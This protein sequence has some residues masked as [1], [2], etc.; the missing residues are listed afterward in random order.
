MPCEKKWNSLLIKVKLELE[1][2]AAAE[3]IA[4]REMEVLAALAEWE[5]VAVAA[6]P[7]LRI[8]RVLTVVVFGTHL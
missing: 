7:R 4:A 2:S 8:Q 6:M 3:R 5:T 1:R